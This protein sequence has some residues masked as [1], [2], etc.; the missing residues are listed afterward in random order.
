MKRQTIYGS[1]A[2]PFAL[3]IRSVEY[4]LNT[5]TLWILYETLFYYSE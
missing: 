5:R 3:S 2:L 1:N 4:E